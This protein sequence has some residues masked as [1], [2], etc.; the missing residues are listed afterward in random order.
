MLDELIVANTLIEAFLHNKDV[1]TIKTNDPIN[2]CKIK[3]MGEYHGI[4]IR[5]FQEELED[6]EMYLLTWDSEASDGGEMV[7]I[8]EFVLEKI[9]RGT[10]FTGE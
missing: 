6:A 4:L 3:L 1:D 7:K 10:L 9:A 2:L 8:N 5:D